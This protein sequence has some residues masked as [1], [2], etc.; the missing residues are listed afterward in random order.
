MT[1]NRNAL[2]TF[3][4]LCSTISRILHY[5]SIFSCF[6]VSTSCSEKLRTQRKMHTKFD[7]GSVWNVLYFCLFIQC[8]WFDFSRFCIFI[9]DFVDA[10]CL[11]CAKQLIQIK[12]QLW[13]MNVMFS[14]FL[15]NAVIV[16]RNYHPHLSL[17][18]T[19]VSKWHGYL[20]KKRRANTFIWLH[21]VY[22]MWVL[23][24]T[25]M[26]EKWNCKNLCYLL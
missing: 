18:K 5:T 24:D 19:A 2:A 26:S 8:I 3:V 1:T 21:S 20:K 15:F 6:T 13:G 16:A 7:L 14:T 11:I 23:W 17:K 10:G 25:T 4:S 12:G 9:F 22:C